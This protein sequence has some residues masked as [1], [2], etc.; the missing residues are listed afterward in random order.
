MTRLTMITYRMLWRLIG[1]FL[2]VYLRWR[3]AQGKEEASRLGER[4]GVASASRPRGQLF[5]L[6]GVSV[7]ETV[8]SLVLAET[9]L[10][11]R[12]DAHILITSGTVTSAEMAR[13][14]ITSDRIIHQYHP[15]DHP[16]WVSRFLDHW[17]PD[18]VVMMESEIWPN[19]V[20]LSAE[21]CPV[22]MAS[23]QVSQQSHNTW[24]TYG[25][26]MAD[27]VFPCFS[28]IL[29][30][31]HDQAQ[32]FQTLH[33]APHAVQIGGSMKAAAEAL[34]DQPHQRDALISAADGRQVVLLASSH[35]QEEGVF[36]EAMRAINQ[37][38]A[39]FA[40][41]A[42]RHINRGDSIVQHI[43]KKD[44]KTNDGHP[45][46]NRT[47][48]R[49]KADQP[50]AEMSWWV[51]DAMG[52]M[53][54]LIRAADLIVLGGGFAPLG[55]HN[56]MEMASLG[57]GVISGPHVFKNK[58]VFDMLDAHKGVIFVENAAQLAEAITLLSASPTALEQLN[59]GAVRTADAV[60]TAADETASTLIQLAD[61]P[62]PPT[63]LDLPQDSTATKGGRS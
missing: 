48:Q 63:H 17:S 26:W 15:H 21:I 7:G 31:D 19:M 34:P 14:R 1:L 28:T 49:S 3:A 22:A 5:W 38:N 40:V 13:Q 11:M 12:P 23:A 33:N 60:K 50:H 24:K 36:I 55:G 62:H 52:E 46:H 47:G 35:D 29:A 10:K 25:R 4:Y 2:P 8:S 42:P 6:H 54:S 32:R 59:K 30:V 41:I 37:H 18:L 20:T 39:Y 51:A 9:L 43:K 44:P 57:K 53:G 61:P 45:H 56:P 27:A 58:S 16:R